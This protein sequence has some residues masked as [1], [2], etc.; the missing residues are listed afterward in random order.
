[1]TA[2][3]LAD[4]EKTPADRLDYDVDY[5]KWLP[6]ED[7]IISAYTT[8]TQEVNFIADTVEISEQVVRVW[9]S[10]GLDG[11]V[12]EIRVFATTLAGRTKEAR[13]SLTIRDD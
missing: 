9:M 5:S 13:F 4:L 1:M 10:G 7:V 11:E 2:T 6:E 12:S 3:I 8:L